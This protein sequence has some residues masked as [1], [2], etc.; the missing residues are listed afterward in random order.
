MAAL[1]NCPHCSKILSTTRMC[2]RGHTICGDCGTKTL[3]PICKMII[4]TRAKNFAFEG[5]VSELGLV[6]SPPADPDPGPAPA[7]RLSRHRHHV[8]KCPVSYCRTRN[9]F[10]DLAAHLKNDHKRSILKLSAR[11]NWTRISVRNISS[12]ICKVVCYSKCF[13]H[14]FIKINREQGNFNVGVTLASNSLKK[15]SFSVN[16]CRARREIPLHGSSPSST[17]N[18]Y[19]YTLKAAHVEVNFFEE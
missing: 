3:C 9:T 13:F 10:E 11:R 5:L 14:I 16:N 19:N 4:C 7:I 2:L 12:R 8:I 18:N 6:L 1:W 17:F 15:F